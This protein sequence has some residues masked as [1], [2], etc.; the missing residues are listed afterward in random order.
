M[1]RGVSLDPPTLG[2]GTPQDMGW[3]TPPDLG[4]DTP[5]DL[6]QGTPLDMGQGNPPRHGTGY[7]P[8]RHIRIA[9]TCYA[10]GGMLLRSR[11]RTFL[12]IMLC[13]SGTVTF[14]VHGRNLL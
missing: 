6:G 3:G 4:W 2:W 11:R 10:A 8:P 9:S 7:P 5:P 14:P 1:M 12:L 13:K